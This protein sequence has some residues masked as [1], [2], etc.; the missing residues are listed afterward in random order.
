MFFSSDYHFEAHQRRID[1]QVMMSTTGIPL[2]AF[3]KQVDAK[4]Q[5]CNTLRQ[6]DRCSKCHK[7]LCQH[8]IHYFFCGQAERGD[9]YHKSTRGALS[10][11]VNRGGGQAKKKAVEKDTGPVRQKKGANKINISLMMKCSRSQAST[12]LIN[13]E[14]DGAEAS[15]SRNSEQERT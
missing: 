7:L 13:D 1:E 5:Q 2:E 12:R 4:C 8:C 11:S 9:I 15:L 14:F 10:M 6:S 3:E